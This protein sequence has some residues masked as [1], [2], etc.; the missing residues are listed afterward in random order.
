M[1]R[2]CMQ[3]MESFMILEKLME[4]TQAGFQLLIKAENLHGSLEE[5]KIKP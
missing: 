5:L 3:S 2:V 1:K 4:N